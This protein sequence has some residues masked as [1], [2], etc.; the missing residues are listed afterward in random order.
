MSRNYAKREIAYLLKCSVS[1]V[2]KN[3]DY[4][5]IKPSKGDR[6]L[7][8]YSQGD[9][10]LLSQ[11]VE[12]CKNPALSRDSFVPTAQIEIVE[13]E[14]KVSRISTRYGHIEQ[15][16]SYSQSLAI[17]SEQDPL[18]DLELL[19]RISNN[20]WL[21]PSKRLAPLFGISA[22]QLNSRKEYCYCGFMATKEAYA[23]GKILWKITANNQ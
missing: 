8:L 15:D 10:N 9:F 12:H 3:A 14:P 17:A 21:L 1:T 4:L 18:F 7:N 2:E 5:K 6:G 20:R 23:G 22:K 19:Q 13:D 11:L 16:D